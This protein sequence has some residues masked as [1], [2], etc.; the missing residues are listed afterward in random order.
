MLQNGRPLALQDVGDGVQSHAALERPRA[1]PRETPE[2]GA[3]L[4]DARVQEHEP[5]LPGLPAGAAVGAVVRGQR[6]KQECAPSY[7]RISLRRRL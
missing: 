2:Q 4:P 3:E 1:G 6:V 7:Q 5:G